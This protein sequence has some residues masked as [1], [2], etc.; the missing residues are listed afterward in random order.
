MKPSGKFW[1]GVADKYARQP[2]KDEGAY[3]QTLDRIRSYLRERD[4][5]LE[6]GC[7]TGSTAL[8]LAPQVKHLQATD[9]SG[10]MIEIARDKASTQKVANVTF[11]TMAVGRGVDAGGPFDVVMGLNLLHLVEDLPGA[12]AGLADQ[13]TKGG[14]LITKTVCLGEMASIWRM[15]LPVMQ[16]VGKAPHVSFLQIADLDRAIEQAGFE[17]V[18]TGNYPAS[19]PNHFVVAR[20]L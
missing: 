15:I 2:I 8:K 4:K 20:K 17:I 5:V 18:E 10:R 11:S 6:V 9:L 16:F 14:L 13:T 1:D 3:A 19:P 12:L 7:G